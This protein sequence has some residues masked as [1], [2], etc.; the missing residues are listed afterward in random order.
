M[1]F[2]AGICT[3]QLWNIP[4]EK[5]FV[6]LI[7][8]NLFIESFVNPFVNIALIFFVSSFNSFLFDVTSF[9]LLSKPVLFTKLAI[10]FLLAKF[11]CFNLAAK[12]YDVKLFNSGVVIYLSWLW[13][14]IFFSISFIFSSDV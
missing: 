5:Y 8:L 10:S 14:I 11:A 13:S 4:E 3:K 2:A 9:T 6:P 12:F 7:I 1:F